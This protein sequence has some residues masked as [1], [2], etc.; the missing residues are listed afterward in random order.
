MRSGGPHETHIG[1]RIWR[2][3]LLL[4]RQ[5]IAALLGFAVSVVALLALLWLA[6]RRTVAG[7]SWATPTKER[8]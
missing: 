5:V 8:R 6:G 3:A 1:G 7:Y 4:G 2:A